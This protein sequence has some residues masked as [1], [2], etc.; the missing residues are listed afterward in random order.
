MKYWLSVGVIVAIGVLIGGWLWLRS[1]YVA[2]LEAPGATSTEAVLIRIESG[3]S[4][5]DIALQLEDR[6]LIKNDVVFRWY[7]YRHGLAS[8]IQAGLYQLHGSL[9]AAEVA[10]ILTAGKIAAHSVTITSGLR[11]DQIVDLLVEEGYSRAAVLKAFKQHYPQTILQ[12]K[13]AGATLEG[14]L[15]PD[16]YRVEIDQPVQALID[17]I[18]TNT[19]QRITSDIRAAWAVRGLNLH[20][21]LTLASIVQ[22]EVA[23]EDD[24]RQVAQVFLRRLK[25]GM[26]LEADPTYEYAA[27][28]L[29]VAPS[30]HLDSPY[31]TYRHQGLPPTPIATIDLSAARSI[32]YPAATNW[33]YFLADRDGKTHFTESVNQHKRNIEK[34]LQ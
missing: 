28:L 30:I 26:K 5:H 9:P 6:R 18:L 14:Y 11:L 15:F 1:W 31:N 33:L 32:A 3:S 13:P 34:Y 22:K 10:E 4:L 29:D 23:N 2:N 19:E 12:D 17:L 27:A 24:Q 21:G 7:L 8:R 20:Q 16:T 25:I